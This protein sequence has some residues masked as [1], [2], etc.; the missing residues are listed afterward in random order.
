MF[1]CLK[2]CFGSL[3]LDISVHTAKRLWFF[4]LDIFMFS[5]FE[6]YSTL[7]FLPSVTK[8]YAGSEYFKTLFCHGPAR[9][10]VFHNPPDTG[11][12]VNDFPISVWFFLVYTTLQI[13][14]LAIGGEAAMYFICSHAIPPPSLPLALQRHPDASSIA[15]VGNKE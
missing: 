6:I 9:T 12:T 1:L 15:A 4:S 3:L 10:S 5:V 2:V 11:I 14:K 7:F 8:A 13:I